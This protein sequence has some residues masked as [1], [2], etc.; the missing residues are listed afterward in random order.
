MI[1]AVMMQSPSPVGLPPASRLV[2]ALRRVPLSYRVGAVSIALVAVLVFNAFIALQ[3]AQNVFEEQERLR[4]GISAQHDVEVILS[5]AKDLENGVRGYFIAG[6]PT[7]L[8]P[9]ERAR[10]QLPDELARLR[11]ELGSDA[12]APL[13]QFEH[14]VAG[15]LDQSQTFVLMRGQMSGGVVLD[16]LRPLVERQKERT[17]AV[18]DSAS[19]LLRQQSHA[20]SAL[21]QDSARARRM[22]RI[23]ILAPSFISILLTAFLSS[24]VIR[25]LRQRQALERQREELL[26]QERQARAEAE[27]ASQAKDDFVSTVSHELRTPLQAILGWTQFLMRLIRGR[28]QAPTAQLATQLDTIERNARALARMIDDL[29]DVSRAITGKLSLATQRVDLAEIVRSSVDVSRSAA[30]AKGVELQLELRDAP[31]WMV[32]D[33][34]RLRQVTINVVGNAVKF[35]PAGGRVTV[36][37]RRVGN[38]LELR[39]L[40]TGIGIAPELLPR[41]FE[42]YVQGSVSSARQY[43]GLGL[44]LAIVKHLVEMH[45]GQ[46]AVR[47]DGVGRG[48]EF[49]LG[50]PIVAVEPAQAAAQPQAASAPPPPAAA[51]G[52]VAAGQRLAGMRLLVVDDDPDVRNVLDSLLCAEGARVFSAASAADAMERLRLQRMDAVLSDI[53]MP[54]TDGYALARRIRALAER[55][56]ATPAAVPLIAFT[57]FSREEDARRAL[58]GGFDA[59]IGKPAELEQ[60]IEVLRRC[61]APSAHLPIELQ[62]AVRRG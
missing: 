9:Y 47:S 26:R 21:G 12:A 56:S 44:G 16:D 37:V 19:A 27:A 62:A 60:L 8:E 58:D 23:S 3:S 51:A 7:Y 34:D 13:Q 35:T 57:A 40:D 1:S 52:A 6:D 42:R 2:R 61:V 29:L 15:L 45:G 50:F 36:R 31:L 59:H 11:S 18:R 48:A 33:A 24:L 4:V 41:I 17:D 55:E 20:T 32:G 10:R 53:G 14:D 54:E 38:R 49:I 43:G 39:V 30:V 28:E 22:A 25:D 46:V 5:H